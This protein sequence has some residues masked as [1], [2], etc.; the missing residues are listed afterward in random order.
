MVSS[1]NA[2]TKRNHEF[3]NTAVVKGARAL[4]QSLTEAL[5][6]TDVVSVRLNERERKITAV[7]E[8]YCFWCRAVLS[9]ERFYCKPYL[10]LC[11]RRAVTNV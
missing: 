9:L 6:N 2:L 4:G 8:R 7:K 11:T 5:K 1:E 3:V 10:V